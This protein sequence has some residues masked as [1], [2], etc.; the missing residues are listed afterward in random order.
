MSSFSQLNWPGRCFKVC[1]K[2]ISYCLIALTGQKKTLE[3]KVEN[4]LKCLWRVDYFPF[5]LTIKLIQNRHMVMYSF[6]PRTAQWFAHCFL[7]LEDILQKHD[8]T[9]YYK[10]GANTSFIYLIWKLKKALKSFRKKNT[11]T[12]RFIAKRWIK[13]EVLRDKD[14][15]HKTRAAVLINQWKLNGSWA[16]L[17]NVVSISNRGDNSLFC[18]I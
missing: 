14:Y 16:S 3:V 17:K 4:V 18:L 10:K 8:I 13:D 12:Q 9:L 15:T 6:C 11:Q 1:L 7:I 5:E 2:N